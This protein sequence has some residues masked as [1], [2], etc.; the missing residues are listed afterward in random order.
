MSN[1]LARPS[2]GFRQYSAYVGELL[3]AKLIDQA[4]AQIMLVEGFWDCERQDAWS[5]GID[6]DAQA[7]DHL[8]QSKPELLKTTTFK[9]GAPAPSQ[10]VTQR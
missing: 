3:Q 9:L 6:L 2:N 10:V 1:L 5:E 7:L 4:Q 8:S